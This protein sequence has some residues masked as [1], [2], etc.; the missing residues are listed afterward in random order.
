M[1]STG[2]CQVISAENRRMRHS[3]LELIFESGVG[4]LTETDPKVMIRWSDDRGR[5]WS[6]EHLRAL[7]AQ[8]EYRKRAFISRLGATR[9]RIYEWSVSSAVRRTLIGATVEAT[10]DAY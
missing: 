10:A 3:R 8:G 7:G 2:T 4:D 5:T 9:T 1:I 6:N